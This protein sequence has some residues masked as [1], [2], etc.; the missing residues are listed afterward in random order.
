MN[1]KG[2][3]T[4]IFIAVF[5]FMSVYAM[6]TKEAR[7]AIPAAAAGVVKI[8]LPALATACGIHFF[9]DEKAQ[10][11]ALSVYHNANESIKKQFNKWTM[12]KAL[13]SSTMWNYLRAC[14]V[15]D[16]ANGEFEG[17][18]VEPGESFIIGSTSSSEDIIFT[19]YASELE[20]K[21]RRLESVSG[22]SP[23][24]I[25]NNVYIHDTATPISSLT[26]LTSSSYYRI[27]S[28]R[29]GPSRR[30]DGY[31]DAIVKIVVAGGPG[32]GIENKSTGD[33]VLAEKLSKVEVLDLMK[34]MNMYVMV[35]G[36]EVV[37]NWGPI[38]I[39]HELKTEYA[40]FGMY[41]IRSSRYIEHEGNSTGLIKTTVV[42]EGTDYEIYQEYIDAVRSYQL[43]LEN[44]QLQLD[45]LN[46][47]TTADALE[48]EPEEIQEKLIP[49]YVP[50]FNPV[51]GYE[52]PA[53]EVEGTTNQWLQ[54]L[55]RTMT[56][57]KD[58]V[59]NLPGTIMNNFYNLIV[60]S[61]GYFMGFAEQVRNMWNDKFNLDG[62]KAAFNSTV[63]EKEFEGIWVTLPIWGYHCILA[64]GPLLT[65]AGTFKGIFAAFIYFLTGLMVFKRLSRIGSA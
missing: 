63:Q 9:N 11:W 12:E 40:E 57:V 34:N 56:G 16:I 22:G 20:M 55:W 7:A 15:G 26:S 5:S 35:V 61:D 21:G 52:P 2:I 39:T 41:G 6:P 28:F 27:V 8:A 33:V 1:R 38:S 47:S 65:A 32:A 49:G 23:S 14:M 29:G 4:V 50:P 59:L 42:R 58:A 43:A 64:P 60:P 31:Y 17:T 24:T 48:L 51:E 37:A 45:E 18:F 44:V 25:W 30:S 10:E 36:N 53:G 46:I 13:I 62:L 3:L 54:E 19:G